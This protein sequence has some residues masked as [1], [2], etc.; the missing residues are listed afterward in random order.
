MTLRN[1][2]STVTVLPI[3]VLV[4]VR[5]LRRNRDTPTV[6]R[7]RSLWSRP[8]PV[9]I[10]LGRCRLSVRTLREIKGV[11]VPFRTVLFTDR[12]FWRRRTWGL[13]E[14][15]YPFGIHPFLWTILSG[16]MSFVGPGPL[17][18]QSYSVSERKGQVIVSP[19]QIGIFGE[20]YKEPISQEDR[21]SFYGP[22]FLHGSLLFVGTGESEL[23]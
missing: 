9:T 4:T 15:N 6:R 7:G 19:S 10:S 18:Y 14:G 1:T 21:W 8:S 12:S 23:S 11:Y 17:D 16:S 3:W 22:S 20:T 5:T 13:K 2:W